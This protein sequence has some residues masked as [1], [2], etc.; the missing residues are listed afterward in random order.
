MTTP[1]KWLC[2]Q[3]RL[4]SAWASAQSVQSLRCAHEET[5]CPQVP[6]ERTAKTL[7]RS[8]SLLGAHSFCWLNRVV[9]HSVCTTFWTHYSTEDPDQTAP[10]PSLHCLPF[11]LRH[12]NTNKMAVRPAKTQ[13]SMGIRPVCSE[14]SLCA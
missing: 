2:A 6:I 7:I 5:L 13:I 12:D 1:T 8:E 14:S 4:R 3:R 10:G 9:A 11:E